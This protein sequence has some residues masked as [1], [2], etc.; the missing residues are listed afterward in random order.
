MCRL[1]FAHGQ[2]D[3][4]QV[5]LAANDMSNGKTANHDGPI[6]VHPN[7]WGAI[8]R[9]KDTGGALQ[10]HLSMQAL[11]LNDLENSPL[12]TSEMDM[13]AL[14]ARHA[15]VPTKVG[16]EFAHPLVRYGAGGIWYFMHNGYTPTI[17][18]LLGK[19]ESY[20]DSLDYFEYL[21]DAGTNHIVPAQALR[22]LA[23]VPE[24]G[25]A[26]NAIAIN[27][28]SAYIVHYAFP[29]ARFVRYFQMYRLKMTSGAIYS[30]EVLPQ[31]ASASRWEE[32][33]PRRIFKVNF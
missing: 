3:A 14:H 12:W 15:T 20:F 13:L 32:L 21:I 18:T 28:H 25:S 16:I 8:W 19:A 27:G 6:T 11:S 17:H 31:L 26:A 33:Q 30:S 4:R 23:A 9:G 29:S 5:M 10:R 2:F 1:I 7:G 24:G 22:K